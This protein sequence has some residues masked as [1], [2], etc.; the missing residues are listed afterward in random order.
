MV[1]DIHGWRLTEAGVVAVTEAQGRYR[2]QA[3]AAGASQA[4]AHHEKGC[5]MSSGGQWPPA[6]GGRLVGEGC[7]RRE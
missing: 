2:G 7:S 6:A 3:A 1:P 4:E 5:A